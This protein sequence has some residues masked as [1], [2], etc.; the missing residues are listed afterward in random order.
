MFSRRE[1]MQVTAATAAIMGA[2]TPLG[3]LAA[4]QKNIPK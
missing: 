1:F 3:A 2:Q 4:T